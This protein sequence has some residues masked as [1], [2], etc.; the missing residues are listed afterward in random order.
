MHF[1]F[2][3]AILSSPEIINS[4]QSPQK[5]QPL[6]PWTMPSSE[7]HAKVLKELDIGLAL[8]WLFQEMTFQNDLSSCLLIKHQHLASTRKYLIVCQLIS[9][10]N[11][12]QAKEYT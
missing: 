9:G 6:C 2:T 8:E 5:S 4:L 3:V 7:K 10:I 12:P 11:A 1:E